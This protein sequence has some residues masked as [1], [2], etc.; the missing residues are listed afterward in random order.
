[1]ISLRPTRTRA[2]MNI[3]SRVL[4][5]NYFE[6]PLIE[7]EVDMEL[8]EKAALAKQPCARAD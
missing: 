1:M 7:L 4:E 3:L 2:V 5:V 8:L 6:A